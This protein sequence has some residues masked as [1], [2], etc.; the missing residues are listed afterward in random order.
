MKKYL[1]LI[2]AGIMALCLVACS[3]KGQG[4]ERKG[5]ARQRLAA[6]PSAIFLLALFPLTRVFS[7]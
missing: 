2:L 5:K 1:K 7:F 6:I 4:Q 3:S